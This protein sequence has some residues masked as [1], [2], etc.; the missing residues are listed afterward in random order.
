MT[1]MEALVAMVIVAIM[2]VATIN[3]YLFSTSRAEWSS[4]SLAAH[5]LALQR[6][7]QT[8]VAS[9]S[10]AGEVPI[11]ELT[12]DNFPTLHTAL[13]LPVA[14]TNAVMATVYTSITNISA[15]PPLK[16]IRVECVWPFRERGLFTN[17]LATYRAADQ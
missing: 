12:A 11:D 16:M 3:G 8:R 1:F 6:L 15:N 4:H 2:A 13:D 14:G 5:A 10:L 9:W 17:Q 7:E